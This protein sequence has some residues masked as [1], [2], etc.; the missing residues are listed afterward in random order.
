MKLLLKRDQKSGMMGGI[1]FLLDVR[2]ELSD[3]EQ[4]SVSKY[5]LGT[6]MLY[7][8]DKMV[9]PGSGLLGAASRLSFKM[10]NLSVNVNDLSSGRRIECKD[11][12]EMLA[13]EEQIKQA[14]QTFQA[15]LKAASSF[16]GE[17]V[18]EIQ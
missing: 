4:L 16:G 1:T 3:Q 17:E 9:D 14:C 2:A 6:T 5:K 10:T 15:V 11:I 18:I 7:E 13:V 12:I 8:R